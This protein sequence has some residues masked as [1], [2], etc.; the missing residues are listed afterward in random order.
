MCT[1]LQNA[2]FNTVFISKNIIIMLLLMENWI[3]LQSYFAL[4]LEK[5]M[6]VSLKM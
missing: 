6:S 2:F 4:F 5:G 3:H 1:I